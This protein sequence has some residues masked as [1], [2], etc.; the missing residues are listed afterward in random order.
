MTSFRTLCSVSDVP[1]GTGKM[2]MVDDL[3]L[4]VFRVEGEIFVIDNRCPHAG[5][6]LAAGVVEG[7]RVFCRIHYWEFD[8]S[9]G[10][11][12]DLP[13]PAAVRTY[14]VRVVDEQVQVDLG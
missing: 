3:Q 8:L 4:G 7:K 2:V 14:A 5:A 11:R 6:S 12:L 1:E 13:C 9:T 10:D